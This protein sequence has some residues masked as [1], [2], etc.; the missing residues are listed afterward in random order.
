MLVGAK[1]LNQFG[2]GFSEAGVDVA[3]AEGD[4]VRVDGPRDEGHEVAS[5]FSIS[6]TMF[7]ALRA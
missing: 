4:C 3:G 1:V 2:D 6:S 7:S 5:S